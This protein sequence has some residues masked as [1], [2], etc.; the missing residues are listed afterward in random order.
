[1]KVFHRVL[2]LWLAL[3]MACGFAL[4]AAAA[5]GAG[6]DG[7]VVTVTSDDLTGKGLNPGRLHDCLIGDYNNDRVIL[8]EDAR[9]ALRAAVALEKYLRQEQLFLLDVDMDGSVTAADARLILRMSVGLEA[10][11]LLRVDGYDET[12]SLDQPGVEF[13]VIGETLHIITHGAAQ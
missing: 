13:V 6:A 2:V 7:T 9:I 8:A 5:N 1:M 4:T 11:K 3:C 12:L 10:I